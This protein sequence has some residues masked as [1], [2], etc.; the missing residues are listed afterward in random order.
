MMPALP[1]SAFKVIEAKIFTKPVTNL[2]RFE[3]FVFGDCPTGLDPIALK[4]CEDL[5]YAHKMF[6]AHW[7]QY[8][9]AAGPRRNGHMISYCLSNLSDSVVCFAFRTD[10]VSKGTDDCMEQA[11]QAGISVYLT[12]QLNQYTAAIPGTKGYRY[13]SEVE[14][15]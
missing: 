6:I 10:G 1:V 2:D 7:D 13:N 15:P 8:G 4:V 11:R 12:R 9:L 3:E 5:G 14:G